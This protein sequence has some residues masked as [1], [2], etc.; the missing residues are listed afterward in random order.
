M[1]QWECSL[2]SCNKKRERGVIITSL[3]LSMPDRPGGGQTKEAP[4]LFNRPGERPIIIAL[5]MLASDKPGGRWTIIAPLMRLPD[6]SDKRKRGHSAEEGG[7][8]C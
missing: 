1:Q 2:L 4:F 7:N 8:Q 3:S 6:R 5:F